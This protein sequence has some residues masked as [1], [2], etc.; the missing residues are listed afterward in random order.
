MPVSS[1]NLG[2][3]ANVWKYADIYIYITTHNEIE[4]GNA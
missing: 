3:H 2:Y 4:K 1:L